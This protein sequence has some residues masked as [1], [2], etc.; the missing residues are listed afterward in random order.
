[1]N[2]FRTSPH[3]LYTI[4]DA[5]KQIDVNEKQIR[6]AIKSGELELAH[7][8]KKKLVSGLTLRRLEKKLEDLA[9]AERLRA[10]LVKS[11]ARVKAENRTFRR[12]TNGYLFEFHQAEERERRER[13]AARAD[14]KK[15]HETVARM[16]IKNRGKR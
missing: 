16:K 5:A 14:A 2:K 6:E 8:S 11:T 12:R 7:E 1:M 9:A 10:L 3:L 13:R 4:E 15:A